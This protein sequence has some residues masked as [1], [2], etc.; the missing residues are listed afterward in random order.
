MLTAGSKMQVIF[1]NPT[2]IQRRAVDIML[3]AWRN[4]V[5]WFVRWKVFLL[6]KLKRESWR[7]TLHSLLTIIS[8]YGKKKKQNYF[9]CSNTVEPHVT[10]HGHHNWVFSEPPDRRHNGRFE[11]P[12]GIPCSPFRWVF[13]PMR[14][15]AIRQSLLE[16]CGRCCLPLLNCLRAWTR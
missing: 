12:C 3:L 16:P 9:L 5:Q 7:R 14:D 11:L 8:I 1:D 13:F 4:I 10:V 15:E 2:V 6:L